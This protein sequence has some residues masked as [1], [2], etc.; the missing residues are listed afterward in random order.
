MT[1]PGAFDLDDHAV[2]TAYDDVLVPASFRRTMGRMVADALV[3][4]KAA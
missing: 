3:A 1:G 4:G 2:A